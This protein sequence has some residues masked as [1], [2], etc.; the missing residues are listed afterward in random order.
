MK[1][2]ELLAH[3]IIYTVPEEERNVKSCSDCETVFTIFNNEKFRLNYKGM[4]TDDA[5][6]LEYLDNRFE[7][8]INDFPKRCLHVEICNTLGDVD[9]YESK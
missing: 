9:N 2:N 4:E 3:E 1:K 8:V 5:Y 6:V 7:T